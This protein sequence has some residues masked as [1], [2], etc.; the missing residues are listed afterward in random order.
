MNAEEALLP[1][2]DCNQP[3]HAGGLAGEYL[4]SAL[5]RHPRYPDLDP[6]RDASL[7]RRANNT[8]R[9]TLDNVAKD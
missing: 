4:A 1:M 9:A 2:F 6:V 5:E 8:T 3:D 7:F